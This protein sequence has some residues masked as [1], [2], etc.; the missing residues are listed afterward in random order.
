M[1]KIK[2]SELAKELDKSSRD[3]IVALKKGCRVFVDGQ[4]SVITEEQAE[5]VKAYL[6]KQEEEKKNAGAG[7]PVPSASVMENKTEASAQQTRR[8]GGLDSRGNYVADAP[9]EQ[10]AARPA[11]KTVKAAETKQPEAKPE[12]KPA[13]K[14]EVK[15]APQPEVK[16]E[17]KPAP[18]PEAK[19]A[20]KAE[21]K[22]APKAEAKPAAKPE[23]KPAAA[24]KKP[25]SAQTPARTGTDHD[26]A[27]RREQGGQRP[28]RDGAAPGRDGKRRDDGAR[29]PRQGQDRDGRSRDGGRDR[30]GR[31]G[32]DGQGARRG[33]PGQNRGGQTGRVNIG[34]AL[35][36]DAPQT[37]DTRDRKGHNKDNKNRDARRNERDYEDRENKKGGKNAKNTARN[38]Q[39]AK[40][41]A[42]AQKVVEK[43]TS[44]ELPESITLQELAEKMK[45][46][47]AQVVKKMFMKGKVYTQNTPLTYDEAEEIAFEYDILCEKEKVVDVIEEML[48]EEEENEADMVP[49]A[50]V[51]CVMGHV[52]HGKTSI[53]DA[54]RNT[55]VTQGEAGGITQ[56][57][58]AYVVDVN[59]QKIT[60]LDTPGHE[61][62]T[63]MRLRGAQSTDIAILVVAADDG[64]MPQTIEAISHAK[65]AGIEIIVAIN[66][67]DKPGANVD[68]VK[69]ELTEYELVSE[70]WG[71]KTIMVPVSAK[72]GQGLDNLLDMILL[73]AEMLELKANPNRLG[74]GLI[75]EAKLDKGRG[76]V[77]TV[78]VQKGT[79]SV[80]SNISVGTAFGRIKAMVDDKGKHVKKAGPST[81]VEITGLNEVPQ[82]GEV[83][84]ETST[85]KE[86][87]AMAEK[88]IVKNREQM[89]AATTQRLSLDSL[90][91]QIREGQIKELNIVLKAD[92]QGSVEAM[93]QSLVKLSNDEVAVK[94]IHGGVGAINESDV[95]LATASNAIIIGFNVKPDNH[96]KN[97]AEQEN[98]DIRLYTV[99][100]KAI[101]DIEAA[102]KGMLEPEFREVITGHAEVR[103]TYRVSGIGTVIGAYVQDGR[104]VRSS[105]VRLLRDNVIVYEGS[106]ASLKRYKDDVKEVNTGYEC[107]MTL[108]KYNDIKE[109]DI[110][111]AYAMEEV[112]R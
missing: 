9:L 30:D 23:E 39:H 45:I 46:P 17:E 27:P 29:G 55:H 89:L 19:P 109:G 49:R 110:V 68:R 37:K 57:I 5:K 97:I 61:A 14:A 43:I 8:L 95:T 80:G 88:F 18:Q 10:A 60:F 76:P 53:L 77:A 81:P 92:V 85:E 33:A 56:H 35:G 66:K 75:L 24:E 12:V 3:I 84:V 7:Q 79:V 86:A 87:R 1:S 6:K 26:H 25:A 36:K 2:V 15:P 21:E 90:F 64:V 59:G 100:Y 41:P 11:R 13:V 107:G 111:E 69:Q 42:P 67:I 106:L 108:E 91:D 82:A 105:K 63:A 32:R 65:A 22:P 78:L 83:F 104:F 44:I 98:V 34:A 112:P 51:V 20:A 48:R 54:I 50:P 40:K 103:Q 93:K 62:F 74:R 52:D 99:I 96:A 31:D 70:D 94:V 102:M 73:V 72:T 101:E 4:N 71:G 38:A 58:G 16:V 47:V 28:R